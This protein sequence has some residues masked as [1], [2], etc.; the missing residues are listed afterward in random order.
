MMYAASTVGQQAVAAGSMASSHALWY[1]V[2]LALLVAWILPEWV[3][4]LLFI[5]ALAGS[6]MFTGAYVSSSSVPYLIVAAI[7]LVGG[8]IWGRI[9]G[10]NQLG[11]SEYRTRYERVREIS[12]WF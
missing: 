11:K 6:G 2:L 9:R 12:R 1:G 5:I 3:A 7:A 4:G 8:L 10:L